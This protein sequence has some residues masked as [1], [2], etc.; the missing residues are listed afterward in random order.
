MLMC[1]Y[2]NSK[3]GI[4]NPSVGTM[5]DALKHSKPTIRKAVAA[6]EACNLIAVEHNHDGKQYRSNHYT[7]LKVKAEVVNEITEVVNVVDQVVNTIDHPSELGLLGVVNPVSPNN[8][9]IDQDSLN[10]ESGKE[11]DLAGA[12]EANPP[13]ESPVAYEM[14][15]TGKPTNY[16]QKLVDPKTGEPITR[17]VMTY[18]TV[19]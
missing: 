7:L 16:S 3:T 5:A 1:R 11:G 18:N 14:K 10:Q 12:R 19:S 15:E 9:Y 13:P 4:C 8:T 6:L 17:I 2:A